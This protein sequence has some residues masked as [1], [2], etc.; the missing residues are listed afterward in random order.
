MAMSVW[1]VITPSISLFEIGFSPARAE[2]EQDHVDDEV[3]MHAGRLRPK[4]ESRITF[5]FS[6]CQFK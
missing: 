3:L 4:A 6:V 2:S 5:I 1:S